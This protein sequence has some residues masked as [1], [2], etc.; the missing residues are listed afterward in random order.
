MPRR[1]D[2]DVTVSVQATTAGTTV[3]NIRFVQDAH[4]NEEFSR[5][6]EALRTVPDFAQYISLPEMWSRRIQDVLRQGSITRQQSEYLSREHA[7]LMAERP[8]TEDHPWENSIASVRHYMDNANIPREGRYAV[9]SEE[10]AERLRGH[11]YDALW[12]DETGTPVPVRRGAIQRVPSAVPTWN[13]NGP[14]RSGTTMEF[15]PLT[16]DPEPPR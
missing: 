8:Q 6:M 9:V 7:R 2:Q 14:R 1:E 5:A 16:G 4:T 3:S 12:V 13:P 15:A 10:D 11:E